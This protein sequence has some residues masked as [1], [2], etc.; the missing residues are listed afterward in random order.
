MYPQLVSVKAEKCRKIDILVTIELGMRSYRRECTAGVC[1]VIRRHPLSAI[2]HEPI[3]GKTPIY[4]IETSISGDVSSGKRSSFYLNY[5]FMPFRRLLQYKE[6]SFFH[7]RFY[8]W[9][10]CNLKCKD[11]KI[12][13]LFSI[14]QNL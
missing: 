9:E 13:D 12:K 1:H 14:N 7:A 5:L 8:R 11:M 3:P 10:T 6:N 4:Y 2:S